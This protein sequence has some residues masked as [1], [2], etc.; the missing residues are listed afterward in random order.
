[1]PKYWMISNRN[2]EKSGLG[3]ERAGLS[4]Y[5][6]DSEDVAQF[7][8]W[9]PCAAADFQKALVGAA[10]AFP[11]FEEHENEKQKH[12]T[13]FIHGYNNSWDDAA[14]RYKQI[15]DTLYT[16]K[17]GLGICILFNWPSNGSKFG[18]LPDREDARATGPSL[19]KVF[20]TI[21]E[22]A[23]L[24]QHKAADG[25]AVCKAKVSVIAHSMGNWVLSNALR[26]AWERNNKP[27]TV[28]LIN[29][30][31]MVAADVDNDIF[32]GGEAIGNGEGEGMANLCYRITALYSGRDSVLGA[33]AGLKHFGKRRLGRSG[34]AK[35]GLP[36]DNVWDYD[37]SDLFAPKESN[38][39]SAYF[40][41]PKIMSVMKDILRG[42][43]R[44]FVSK[45]PSPMK[46]LIS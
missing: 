10:D 2:V 30:C 3:T 9:K 27:L 32:S 38:I 20:N 18:Y 5:T 42:I 45:G 43:D 11:D 36:P 37:C 29:Q 8:T 31:L 14:R 22:H 4:F 1:M 39:H 17:N 7:A 44:E 6:S 35:D 12:V 16:G 24:M 26:Y 15:V 46:T 13:V 40:F 21:Y 34:L 33:S 23:L 25:T 28:S 41:T 19:A